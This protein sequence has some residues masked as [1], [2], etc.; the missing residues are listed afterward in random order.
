MEKGILKK[1]D[2]L[3][4]LRA[5]LQHLGALYERLRQEVLD[6]LKTTTD[7]GTVVAATHWCASWHTGQRVELDTLRLYRYLGAEEFV[8]VVKPQLQLV[9]QVLTEQEVRALARRI[10]TVDR[11][12][13]EARK[14]RCSKG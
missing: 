10:S 11:L 12:V 2:E 9:R 4:E 8:R 5:Q 14:R 13:L 3:G 1:I 6:E 7:P